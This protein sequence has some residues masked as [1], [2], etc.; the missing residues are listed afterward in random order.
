MANIFLDSYNSY[1]EEDEEEKRKKREQEKIEQRREESTQNIFLSK[2]NER[3]PAKQDTEV[4]TTPSR[5]KDSYKSEEIQ[6]EKK[7]LWDKVKGVFSKAK[8]EVPKFFV[9]SDETADLDYNVIR[10]AYEVQ[11]DVKKSLKEAELELEMELG[12]TETDYDKKK[13]EGYFGKRTFL[14][15]GTQDPQKI[16]E[17]ETRIRQ[18]QNADEGIDELVGITRSN[19]GLFGRLKKDVKDIKYELSFSAFDTKKEEGEY[20]LTALEKFYSGEDLT[21]KEKAWLNVYR[22]ESINT[23]TKYGYGDLA[24]GV[25]TGSI[26]LGANMYFTKV[27]TGDISAGTKPVIDTLPINKGKDL[28][29]KIIGNSVQLA[30]QSRFSI[31]AIEGKTAEYMLPSL[32]YEAY[33]S[34]EEGKD[35]DI[36]DYLVEGDDFHKASFKANATELIEFVSEGLGDY[37]DDAVPF[38]KKMFLSKFL[39][40]NNIQPSNTSLVKSILKGMHINSIMGEVFEEEAA[41]PFLSYLEEGDIREYKDPIFTPEGRE[42]LLVEILGMSVMRGMSKVADVTVNNMVGWRKNN[43]IDPIKI[44]VD[45]TPPQ[46]IAGADLPQGTGVAERKRDVEIPQAQDMASEGMVGQELETEIGITSFRGTPV[47]TVKETLPYYETTRAKGF[48]NAINNTAQDFDVQVNEVKRTAGVWEKSIEPSFLLKATGTENAI[49]SYSSNLGSK[50]NQDAVALFRADET[51]SGYKYTYNVDNVDSALKILDNAGIVGATV[52]G[53]NIVVYDVDGSLKNAIIQ[54]AK[55]NN[56]GYTENKGVVRF[57]EK[58]EY[59]KYTKPAGVGDSIYSEVRTSE[60]T[61]EELDKRISKRG[62]IKFRTVGGIEVTPKNFNKIAKDIG[63]DLPIEFINTDSDDFE[64]GAIDVQEGVFTMTSL[65]VLVKPDGKGKYDI[66]DGNHRVVQ[67]LNRGDK[68]IRVTTDEETYRMLS[69]FESGESPRYLKDKKG[70]FKGSVPKGTVMDKEGNI[71]GGEETRRAIE[72]YQKEST[73]KFRTEE[74]LLQ[75]KDRGVTTKFLELPDIKGKSFL[76]K[77]FI[78]N[79][80]MSKGVGLKAYEFSVI[81][82]VLNNQFSDV[83]KIN[84]ADFRRAVLSQMMPLDIIESDTYADYGMSNI[85][86]YEDVAKTYILNSPFY[87]D[88]AGHFSQDFLRNI[89]KE[90]LEIR[91]I[92]V[93]EQNKTPKFVVLDTREEITEENIE[94]A[95][96]TITSTRKASEE[97][98]EDKSIMYGGG[99]NV[100]V[101]KNV[102]LFGHFRS[103]D[104]DETSHIVEIQSDAFQ[105]GVGVTEIKSDLEK[106][107]KRNEY[108]LATIMSQGEE[109]GKSE[110]ARRYK[111]TIEEIKSKIAQQPEITKEEK[112]FQTYKN[113]WQERIVREAINIKAN[114]GKKTI[115]FPTPRTVAVIEGFTGGEEG[116]TMPYEI[117]NG[118]EESGLVAGD[119]IDYGG[120]TY[121]VVWA[122]DYLISVAPEN[123]VNIF[124]VD[125]YIEERVNADWDDVNYDYEKVVEEYGKDI[126]TI[127]DVKKILDTQDTLKRLHQYSKIDKDTKQEIDI[128]EGGEKADIK[129]NISNIKD[130]ISNYERFAELLK[131]DI[132]HKENITKEN[133]QSL[134]FKGN[135]VK[136]YRLPMDY[137]RYIQSAYRVW[138]TSKDIGIDEVSKNVL[139]D[140]EANIKEN[141]E[142]LSRAE[143]R[144]EEVTQEHQRR[145]DDIK[146][147]KKPTAKELKGIPQEMIDKA[148][149]PDSYIFG[150]N[151]DSKL[152]DIFKEEVEKATGV[153]GVIDEEV[154][155]S[156]DDLSGDWISNRIDEFDI[157]DDLSGLYEEYYVDNDTAYVLISGHGETLSQPDQYDKASSIE[158]FNIED[159]EGEQ[160]TVLEFYNKQVIPYLKKIRSDLQL[161]EDNN[162]Y[163]WWESQLT[164]KDLEPPTAYRV[165]DDFEQIGI[166]ITDKQ[167][168]QIM[169]LNK[170]MFGDASVKITEQILSN[171]KALGAYSKKIIQIL[172]GQVNPKDTF[173]HEAVHKYIDVFLTKDEQMDLF[174]AGAKKYKTNDIAKVEERLAEDFISYAKSR[175]GITGKIKSIFDK[176]ISRIQSYLGNKDLIEETY[177]NILKPYEAK[178]KT[179]K[180]T[181]TAQN[182][183]EAK[184]VKETVPT[185]IPVGEGEVRVSKLSKGVEAR[186]VA[187]KLIKSFGDLPEYQ[188]V[189]V[190][191]QA[192]RATKLIN[193]DWDTAVNI[194]LGREESPYG[195]LPE[196][197]FIAVENKALEDGSVDLLRQLATSP[198]TSEATAMGQRIRML[199]ERNPDSAVNNIREV[200]NERKKASEKRGYNKEKEVAKLKKEVDNEVKKVSKYDWD[201]FIRSIQC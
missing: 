100:S 43:N 29:N 155:F 131:D 199:A 175:E 62:T 190:D 137:W 27:L 37:I 167:E 47:S 101:R 170:K 128:F 149:D 80:S 15:E 10:N 38:V 34:Q 181:K 68:N 177:S 90:K 174:M 166:T 122:D 103:G 154:I 198:R 123:D 98:I 35:I 132:V 64:S 54:V 63:T 108:A 28:I 20:K 86:L 195:L 179:K 66:V 85:S 165:K 180:V 76:S 193:E 196:S 57:L 51:A 6:P 71:I 172:S 44:D 61:K 4:L 182:K 157:D 60:K 107:L 48:E 116:N 135:L 93:S 159:Y 53:D 82:D 77:S 97:W 9:G 186:A 178:I 30:A 105:H 184:V 73:S 11:S 136:K 69:D 144:L 119:T 42:R 41:E 3:F 95:A 24:A 23:L 104:V 111:E 161:V 18:L 113:I 91:E 163:Q 140:I 121:V 40:N 39:K 153:D 26:A 22:A 49:L 158:D 83:D 74:E 114:E 120:D 125:S 72:E 188:R 102:G 168:K 19:K 87:H 17:L 99:E 160:R 112:V 25:V 1:F 36:L 65:P 88:T 139:F 197:V 150:Y 145:L 94:R 143:G 147:R 142:N 164:E 14:K 183:V 187:E 50:A 200:Y 21:E 133:I 176:I 75:E 16:K 52:D 115:R 5:Y 96:L 201:V 2:Y 185:L 45:K 118:D 138:D 173:Y 78:Q 32:E 148:T 127:G 31:P 194:A 13:V 134:D 129:L 192:E 55:E 151:I 70:R 58:S 84:M 12:K 67:A 126:D 106:E 124:D 146:S 81:Q 110:S 130:N 191:N 141:K 171:N 56:Y 92:P 156:I 117:I 33:L 169:K 46:D 79:L 109:A 89:P 59:S 7:S 189:S 152:E 162:G 8:E